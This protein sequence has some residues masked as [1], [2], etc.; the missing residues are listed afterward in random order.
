M[1]TFFHLG[2]ITHDD[3]VVSLADG[4]QSVSYHNRRSILGNPI[5]GFLHDPLC[6]N[7]DR[8]SGLVQDQDRRISYDAAGDCEPLSLAST[9]LDSAFANFCVVT[10]DVLASIIQ[11][12]RHTYIWE[13]LNEVIGK[14]FFTSFAHHFLPLGCFGLFPL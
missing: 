8:T 4:R 11:S 13:S 3:N 9:K 10:L 5:K 1:G 12:V 7:I 2:S 6:P 14:C